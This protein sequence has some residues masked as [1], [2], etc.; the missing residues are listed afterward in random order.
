MGLLLGLLRSKFFFFFFFVLFC[1]CE[2]WC[3]FVFIFWMIVNVLWVHRLGEPHP[4]FT[5]EVTS[6]ITEKTIIEIPLDFLF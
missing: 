5:V 6:K 3:C 4:W 1:G 2:R